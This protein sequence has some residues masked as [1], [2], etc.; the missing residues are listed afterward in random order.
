MLYVKI[1]DDT[2]INLAQVQFIQFEDTR[3]KFWMAHEKV[4]FQV[5]CQTDPVLPAHV[6]LASEQLQQFKQYLRRLLNY[7]SGP[8]NT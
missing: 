5:A 1:N 6:F 3:I 4:P 8:K 7:L 2:Y